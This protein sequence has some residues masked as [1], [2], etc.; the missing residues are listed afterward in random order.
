MTSTDVSHSPKLC[1]FM[2]RMEVATEQ[3]CQPIR[4]EITSDYCSRHIT[5]H[6]GVYM[7]H[8]MK[9]YCTARNAI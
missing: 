2:H 4:K 9:Q 6:V 8:Y 7:N 1:S 5:I 3:I